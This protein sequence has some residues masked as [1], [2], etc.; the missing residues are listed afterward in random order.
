MDLRKRAI[1]TFL[2]ITL[3]GMI[4]AFWVSWFL[5]SGVLNPI[6]DLVFGS[7]QLA[8]GNLEYQVKLKTKD[9]IGELGETFNLMASSLRE[10]DEQLKEYTQQQIMKSE[11]L[12]TLGQLAAGVAHEINNPLGAILMYTHLFL[13]DMEVEDPR[14]KDIEKVIMETTQCMEIVKGLLD[15]A[16]QTEPKIEESDVNEILKRTLSLVENQALFQNV[17]ITRVLSPTM[18]KVMVDA[19]Q[20]QQVFT[21]I[22]LNAADAVEEEG[23]LTIVTI[24]EPDDES[25]EIEF[26]D[27]GCGIPH[28][29]LEKLFD[30]FFTTK[31]TSRGTGLGLA[32]SYGIIARHKGTIEVKSVSGKGTTFI[33]RL[34]LKWRED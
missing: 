21:N 33:I 32:V 15:F 17:K 18:P 3:A 28:E 30:P 14:R 26:T 34:P 31:E 10:R 8:K 7:Q 29:N 16:R 9:E 2:G 25:I 13:E 24:I 20:I 11:R 5:A 6:K 12:A 23:E 19:S 22:V 27:T 4:V 1:L